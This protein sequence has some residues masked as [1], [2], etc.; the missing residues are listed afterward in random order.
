MAIA[1]ERSGGHR[2]PVQIQAEILR[3]PDILAPDFM[4]FGT[5]H[6]AFTLPD[7]KTPDSKEQQPQ[8]SGDWHNADLERAIEVAESSG[9]QSYRIEIAPDGTISL[10]VGSQD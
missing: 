7:S 6:G 4:I 9:L 3:R 2:R 8:I 10:V 5:G 1:L